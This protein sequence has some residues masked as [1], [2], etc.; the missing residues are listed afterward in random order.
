MLG[1]SFIPSDSRGSRIITHKPE[2]LQQPMLGGNDEDAQTRTMLH[3]GGPCPCMAFGIF[4]KSP[5]AV[6]A[7]HCQTKTEEAQGRSQTAGVSLQALV[8]LKLKNKTY[9]EANGADAGVLVPQLTQ[10]THLEIFRSCS[11]SYCMPDVQLS[12]LT[13]L[14]VRAL[15]KLPKSFRPRECIQK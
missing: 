5:Q 13:N 2:V 10:L 7:C 15:Q 9:N 6:C 11:M 8:H 3:C 12:T 4:R 1:I 14:R